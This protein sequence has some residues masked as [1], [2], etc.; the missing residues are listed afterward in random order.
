MSEVTVRIAGR[1][2]PIICDDGQEPRVAALA[3]RIDAEAT[4]LSG[5]GGGV[6]EAR[7]LLMSALM[8]ADRLDEAEEA[9]AAARANA[10]GGE[11]GAAA[12]QAMTG[13]AGRLDA[14][15]G[16]PPADTPSAEP[17]G[18]IPE[19]VEMTPLQKRSARQA[20]RDASSDDQFFDED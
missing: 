5:A 13:A 12:E 6:G 10:G 9:L 7:L 18:E 19:S 11:E 20:L 17:T 4:A 14:L 8:L 15:R 1:A 2:Y 3:N 16:A